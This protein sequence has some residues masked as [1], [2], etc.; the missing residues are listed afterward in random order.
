M[1]H[2]K[3][4]RR[5]TVGVDSYAIGH[6]AGLAP[7]C[8]PAPG[9]PD[10]APLFC[11][12]FHGAFGRPM[13]ASLVTAELKSAAQKAGITKRVHAHGLRHT[14]A[15]ELAFEGVPLV[16]IRQQLG[17]ADLQ[18]T[19][20]YID[21]LAPVALIRAIQD[22][23]SPVGACSLLVS[24]ASTSQGIPPRLSD[25]L[26]PTLP[27]RLE[28]PLAA[29]TVVPGRIVELLE[30][31]G[32]ASAAQL[33]EALALPVDRVSRE[34]G[35]LERAGVIQGGAL[36]TSRGTVAFLATCLRELA[37]IADPRRGEGQDRQAARGT[38]RT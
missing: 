3:G 22:R 27:E 14:L 11:G 6:L 19:Q 23:P 5:R 2:G 35:E 15:S 10:A 31:N 20:R 24:A 37:A 18:M 7:R 9:M 17:H 25:E 8:G 34:C 4:D 32:R 26:I 21:H 30:R 13:L 38:W 36:R 1:L 28:R 12:M 33:S 29:T 16:V